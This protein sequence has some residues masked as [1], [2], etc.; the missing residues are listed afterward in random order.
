MQEKNWTSRDVFA[1]MI[2]AQDYTVRNKAIIYIYYHFIYKIIKKCFFVND[3]ELK[4]PLAAGA[5][6]SIK[7][8]R[9]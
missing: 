9:E 4:L 5:L 1:V 7:L 6:E 8:T 2:I 3:F